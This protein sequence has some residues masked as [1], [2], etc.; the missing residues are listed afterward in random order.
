MANPAAD[1]PTSV[2]TNTDVSANASSKLGSTSPTHTELEGKQEEE[3]T[4]IQ[5]KIG[6]GASTPTD[7]KVLTGN[8]VGTSEWADP[9][10]VEGTAVA[11]TGETGGSKFLRE[12]GDGTSSWQAIPGGGDML[13]ANN[14]S[15]LTNDA[16]A[17]TNLGVAIGTDVQGVLTEGAFANGDKTKLDGIEASADVT[18]TTNVTSAGALM[19]SELT[20]LAGVKALDTSTIQSK[21]AEGAFVDGDK[22]KLDGIETGAT[23]DQTGAEIKTAYEAEADTNAFTDADHTKL[24]GIEAG[25]DVTDTTNVTAAGALMDSEV[26]NLAQVKAFD[27]TDY[28]TAAQG[29]TADTAVQPASTDT[30]TNKTFDANG[31]GNSLSNVDVAD[32]ANGTDGELITWDATGAPTTVAAGTA[33]HVLT[34]NGPGA[35]P[36]FQAAAGGGGGQTLYDNI[37]ATSGGDYSDF[38]TLIAALSDGESVFV[39]S[40]TYTETAAVNTALNDITFVGENRD[41]SIIKMDSSDRWTWSGSRIVF[42]NLTLEVSGTN[43]WRWSGGSDYVIDNCKIL[44]SGNGGYRSFWMQARGQWTNNFIYDTSP[45]GNGGGKIS[46]EASTVFTGNTVISTTGTNTTAQGVVDATIGSA[47]LT[48]N[49]FYSAGGTSGTPVVSGIAVS[50][51]T[52]QG[53][54]STLMGV[55]GKSSQAS[56]TG[57]N[58]FNVNKGVYS[59]RWSAVSGNKIKL[60]GT[61]PI[62]IDAGTSDCITGN[63]F[64]GSGS[65]TGISIRSSQT[66][67]V[68]T[69]NSF[70]NLGTGVSIPSGASE[71]VVMGNAFNTVTTDISD[72]GSSNL[73]VT[74]TDSDRLNTT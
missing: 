2:H 24:D 30:L 46:L 25:A 64:Y 72:S 3:I 61:T 50:G 4:A 16:T 27:G 42:R 12:D 7:G 15:D 35:A 14:L 36:T 53:D 48:G 45:A 58:I 40:G 19:D 43:D 49:Y 47:Q 31:T 60:S 33:T 6:T 20:D 1:Y 28:A 17:R 69:G 9:A 59:N 65:G 38:S 21:P 55:Y 26:T 57:N 22:T 5:T 8:G 51:N 63:M 56:I 54:N 68:M 23:A 10:A 29:A 70:Y 66:N 37:L 74:A 13:A 39:R 18:D 67:T 32:L 52:V 62:G 34:S 41:E 11:S 73:H 44:I 71:H